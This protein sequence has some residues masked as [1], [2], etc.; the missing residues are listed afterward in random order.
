MLESSESLDE[1][2][3]RNVRDAI[4]EDVGRGDW[5]TRVVPT[6]KL[7]EADVTAM[8]ELVLC[9]RAWFD[10]CLRALGEDTQIRWRHCDGDGVPAG[11]SLCSVVG[12]ARALMTA[13]RVALNFLQT[14]SA[15]ASE[16]RCYV[17]AIEGVSPNE[18]GCAI[19]DTRETVPGLRQAQKYAVRVGGGKNNRHG[20]WDGILITKDHV[21]A[22]GGIP[23][24]LESARR[25]KVGSFIQIEVVD[26]R[27]LRQALACEATDVLLDDFDIGDMAAA[28][29]L[30]AGRAV[31]EV[32]GESLAKVRDIAATGIDRISVGAITKN[33]HAAKLSM[34][35]NRVHS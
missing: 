4:G 14:L 2:L 33:I 1:A 23:A 26:L 18:Q 28:A 30:N 8:S 21:A 11:T 13:E 15:T 16:T 20:L 34:R 32:S 31:L 6:H 19:V 22:A 3:H 35:V 9:G 25:L 17:N 5:S 12:N 24:A 27:G 10:L 29:E 7:A